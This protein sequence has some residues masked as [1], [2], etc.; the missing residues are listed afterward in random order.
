[1]K[2]PLQQL[3]AK[4]YA[5]NPELMTLGVGEKIIV[6]KDF[7]QQ[8]IDCTIVSIFKS[9][10]YRD[11]TKTWEGD[12]THDEIIPIV[13]VKENGLS[14][15]LERYAVKDCVYEGK[16][17]TLVDVRNWIKLKVLE[18]HVKLDAYLR[19]MQDWN[20]SIYL[21]DQSEE[22]VNFLLNLEK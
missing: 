10:T 4:I 16:P 8:K 15:T 6:P 14:D 17:P 7:S 19:L 22:L 20:N 11:N 3:T 5:S 1:M 18:I 13:L 2:T 12:K 21:R 9:N